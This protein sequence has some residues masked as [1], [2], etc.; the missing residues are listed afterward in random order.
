MGRSTTGALLFLVLAACC[1]AGP[2]AAAEPIAVIVPLAGAKRAVSPDD[3]ALIFRR[4]K[5]YWS[6]GSKIIPVNLSASNPI[7]SE[8]SAAVFGEAVEASESYWND[9]YFHGI[10][11]PFVLAS[12]EAVIRFVAQSDGGVGYVPLC[13]ADK[14][15][16]VALIIDSNRQIQP[17]T[18]QLTS[19]CA[20]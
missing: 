14:R 5:L 13:S 7:R 9:M 4:K 20:K 1:G 2:A 11:P 15:V 16:A 12:D 8:F 18:G 17:N 19:L 10:T 3:L 6:D